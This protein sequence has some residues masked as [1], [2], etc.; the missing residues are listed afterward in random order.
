MS[1][2][3]KKQ[4]DRYY[5]QAAVVNR[6]AT[7]KAEGEGGRR[8][9]LL[10]SALVHKIPNGQQLWSAFLY[11]DPARRDAVFFTGSP[12]ELLAGKPSIVH[13]GAQAIFEFEQ[14]CGQRYSDELD[15]EL[16]LS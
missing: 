16:L 8:L 10:K 3:T 12:E 1:R 4:F 11:W 9:R 13:T 14:T 15:L 5:H 6:Q 2:F 7:A